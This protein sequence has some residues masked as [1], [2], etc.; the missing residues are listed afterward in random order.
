GAS[1]TIP[2]LYDRQYLQHK[3]YWCYH[4]NSLYTSCKIQAYANETQGKVTVID[5]PSE[6]LFTVTMKDLQTG[7]TGGYWCVVE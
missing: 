1:V 7:N 3:K 6:S 5:N 2:C 4:Y